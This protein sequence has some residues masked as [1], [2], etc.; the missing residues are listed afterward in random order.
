[1]AQWEDVI[2]LPSDVIQ[3]ES[4]VVSPDPPVPG[5]NLTVTVK[6]SAKETIEVRAMC[7]SITAVH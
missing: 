4:I 1:M 3:L 2:G 7:S 6:G 5:Q